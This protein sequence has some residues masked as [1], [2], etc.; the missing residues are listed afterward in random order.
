MDTRKKILPSDG[1]VP[2]PGMAAAKGWFDV[3]TAEHCRALADAAAAA[4]GLLV[5][6]FRESADR[7]TVLSAADRA[8]LAAGLACVDEVVICDQSEADACIAAW[9]PA[10]V[11][12]VEAFV[13]RDVVADVLAGK[14]SG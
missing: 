14:R 8:Q 1:I 2:R 4:D 12:D 10:A 7:S 11:V 13:K 6:V 3:L 9:R 5:V